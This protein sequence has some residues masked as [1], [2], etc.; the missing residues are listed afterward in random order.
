MPSL[1]EHTETPLA[2]SL[3]LTV[4]VGSQK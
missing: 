3:A 2:N 1:A 4:F